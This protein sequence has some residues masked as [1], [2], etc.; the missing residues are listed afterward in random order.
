MAATLSRPFR[1]SQRLMGT[2]FS[3]DVRDPGDWSEV[4]ADVMTWLHR[5]HAVFAPSPESE[6]S[7][8]GRR[9]LA[10][11]DCDPM[12]REVL[13]TGDRVE[14]VTGGYFAC[15]TR[16]ALDL[17]GIVKGWAAERASDLLTGAGARAHSVRAG[18]DLQLVGGPAPGEPWRVEIRDPREPGA[19]LTVVTG[20]D[21]AVATAGRGIVDP[22]TGEPPTGL[23][24]ITLIGPRLALVDALAT[25][26]FAMGVQARAWVERADHVEA[27]GLTSSGQTWISSG[28]VGAQCQVGTADLDRP[29]VWQAK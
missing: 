1:H 8:L 10:L 18:Q 25:A 7:R 13:A 6:I 20:R 21:L 22:H 5:V 24:S 12:V 3:L 4:A 15:R 28:W 27:I 19:L 16:G 17:A 29:R 14:L 2:V 23:D 11:A 26:A 9:E